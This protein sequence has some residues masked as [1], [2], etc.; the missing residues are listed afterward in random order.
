MIMVNFLLKCTL[1]NIFVK[2]Y[3]FG[4]ETIL[5]NI[6]LSNTKDFKQDF[7]LKEDRKLLDEVVVVGY[8][9]QRK[10]DLVGT[11]GKVGS[12]KLNDQVGSSFETALQG[13]LAGVQLTQSSGAAGGNSIIR[14]RGVGSISAG[15]FPL[16]VLDGVPLSQENYLQGER[17][18]QNNNPLSSIN[19]NDIES[20]SVLKDAA[21]TAIYGARGGNGVILITTKRAKAGKP[22]IAYSAR[23]GISRPSQV[24]RVLNK[25]E[26]L[27]I[28]QEAWKM[29]E[30]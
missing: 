26:W 29:M 2:D 18:G 20:I 9:T 11:V 5:Q 19:P 17:G 13:K 21:S 4:I 12:E 28:Q 8:G 27:Q 10:R 6:D 7:V 23:V 30:M 1:K 3:L 25:S 16:V 22:S 24:L 14:V 15:G